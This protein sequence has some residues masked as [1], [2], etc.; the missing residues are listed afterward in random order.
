MPNLNVRA[1]GLDF[2]NCFMNASGARCMTE[3]ELHA[4]GESKAGAIVIKSATIEPRTGNPEPRYFE[5]EWGSINSMG[6]PNPGYKAYC[7][8]ISRLKKHRKPVI[9]SI[10]GFKIEEFVEMTKAFDA[11]GADAMEIN[12][13]CPN[14][15][16]KSQACY[17][18]DY[19]EEVLKRVR[20]STQKPLTVKLS[21]YLDIAPRVAMAQALKRARIDGVVLINSIGN[22]LIVDPVA[23]RAVIKP[24]DGH[25]GLGGAYIKPVALANVAT[26]YQTLGEEIPIVGVGGIA[27][28]TDAFEHI[29]CGA[30][31]VQ[32]GSQLQKEGPIVFARV[33]NELLEQ[34]KQKGYEK[35]EDVRGKLGM[36]E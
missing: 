36:P 34:M 29:L 3:D 28:G 33:Q 16:G 15:A 1:F 35:L 17:D 2:V 23:E 14:V 27:T 8:M 19:S 22:A 4:L 13:S 7:A 12:L 5:N 18:L 9:A 24:K 25:G 30:R 6:L 31:L 20:A 26:F 32:V 10:A 21:P 11:A